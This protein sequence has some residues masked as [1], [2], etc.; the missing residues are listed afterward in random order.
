MIMLQKKERERLKE[1]AENWKRI[2]ALAAENPDM[3]AI[4]KQGC[5]TDLS[6]SITF[7]QLWMEYSSSRLH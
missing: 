3:E 1:R 7:P 4:A 5:I 6:H 2:E